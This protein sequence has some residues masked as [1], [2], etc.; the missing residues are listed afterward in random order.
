M[1]LLSYAQERELV[2][3]IQGTSAG[4]PLT[5]R[6]RRPLDPALSAECPWQLRYI[7]QPELDRNRATTVRSCYDIACSENAVEFLTELGCR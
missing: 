4:Q 5:L 1:L 3:S 6:V 7:G 2:F